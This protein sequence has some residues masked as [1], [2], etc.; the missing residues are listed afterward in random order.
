MFLSSALV[1]RVDICIFVSVIC[2]RIVRAGAGQDRQEM[3]EVIGLGHGLSPMTSSPRLIGSWIS[4][5]P[6]IGSLWKLV[7]WLGSMTVN[8]GKNRIYALLTTTWSS[9]RVWIVILR[10]C[11]WRFWPSLLCCYWSRPDNICKV[12]ILVTPQWLWT[13]VVIYRAGGDLMES[14][15][16]QPVISDIEVIRAGANQSKLRR[17]SANQKREGLR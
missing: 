5:K 3:D 2:I 6:L 14:G 8:M 15:D 12:L 17:H 16:Q 7:P 4:L 9:P 1:R 10:M 13:G 11:Y